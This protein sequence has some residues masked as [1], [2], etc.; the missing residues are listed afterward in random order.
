MLYILYYINKIVGIETHTRLIKPRW[1]K[2]KL[3]K[4]IRQP[5]CG[6]TYNSNR[7]ETCSDT[8][9]CPSGVG[10][11]HRD[12]D[13]DALRVKVLHQCF[14]QKK[15]PCINEFAKKYPPV[16]SGFLVQIL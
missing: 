13:G 15:R 8:P 2:Y 3:K 9:I 16:G 14:P 1:R 12:A 6:K 11:R 7:T 10:G 5:Y 4:L